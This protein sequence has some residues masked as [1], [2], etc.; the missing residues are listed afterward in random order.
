MLFSRTSVVIKTYV[1][2]AEK[3]TLKETCVEV[4]NEILCKDDATDFLEFVRG[5]PITISHRQ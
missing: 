3:E 4:S 5:R 1:L 2:A